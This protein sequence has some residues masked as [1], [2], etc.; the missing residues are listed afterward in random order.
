[1]ELIC[2]LF[3][4]DPHTRE[5]II[6]ATSALGITVNVIIAVTK[7]ILGLLTSSIA[8][9]SEGANVA[10]DS[11]SSLITLLGTKLAQK[12]PDEKHPFGYGRIE[13][14]VSLVISVLILVTGVEMF[15][16]SVKLI[17]NPEPMNISYLAIGIVFA[18]AVVK[19]CLGTFTMHMGKKA[20]STALVGVGLDSRSDA[21]A[22]AVTIASSLIFLIFHISLDAYAGI[23]I[24][25]LILK[26]GWEVLS[27][28]IA[29]LLGRAGEE[30][31]AK[32]LYQEI[33][34]TPGVLCAVDMMLHNYGP[35]AWSGSV[36]VEIDH[37]RTVGDV[38]AVLHDLQLRIMHEYKVVMVFGIYAVDNDHE[39][40]RALRKDISKFVREEDGV[41][42][43]HA[44]YL[45]SD[46]K[47]L[48]VDFIVDYSQKDWDSLRQRFLDYMACVLPGYKIELTIET[49]F[50]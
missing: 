2:K 22:S 10:A 36:N 9:V 49:Q 14:L 32:Q 8:I 31:L 28:T 13:Y 30:E 42:S 24:S 48:Y 15:L 43:F 50:V 18:T 21:F 47:T 40:V 26:A 45:D 3:R 20:D 37:E 29:D 1:M 6:S 34:S 4:Q 39:E 25:L 38:Y 41:E 5:G 27:P 46:T 44:V 23:F 7:V 33:R 12:H 11:L 16:S 17:F 35:D 19:F